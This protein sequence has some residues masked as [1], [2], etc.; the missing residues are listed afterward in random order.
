MKQVTVA[1][2][3]H[4]HQPYYKDPVE[5][6]YLMPWTRLHGIKG[7]YDM[8]SI[9]E[10]YPQIHGTFNLVPS[11]LLQLCDYVNREAHDI[12]QDKS[13]IPANELDDN[14]KRFIL[15][16][17]FMANWETMIRPHERYWQLLIKRGITEIP[18]QEWPDIIH[19]FSE[20][21]LRDLQVWF[22]LCWFGYRARQHHPVIHE[23]I[24]K[25]KDFSEEDKKTVIET[26]YEV[27]SKLIPLYKRLAESGQIEL[28]TSPFYHPI[29]PLVYDTN[30]AGRAMPDAPLPQR[31][32][33]PNDA[34]TQ[35]ER[36][37]SFFE[38]LFGFKPKGMWPSEGSVCPE[39]IPY[40]AEMGIEWIA[41]DEAILTKS[42]DMTNKSDALF[43]PYTAEYDGKSVSI[44]FRDRGLSDLIGFSYA[45]HS[46]DHASND[47]LSHVRAIGNATSLD[48]P[49]VNIILDGE[50]AWEHFPDGGE[51]FFKALYSKLTDDT[52]IHTAT[53]HDFIS[54]HPASCSIKTLH[55]GSW[56][57]HNYRVWIGG[58]E[59]NRA[60]EYLRKT[61][62][63]VEHYLS[64][65]DVPEDIVKIVWEEIFIAEGSDW[66]W[67]YGDMF[68]TDNDEEFDRLFRLHL[69]N[70][71]K[72]LNTAMPSY[73]KEP[74]IHKHINPTVE[75]PVWYID[76]VIDGLHTHFYEWQ[77]AGFFVTESSPGTTM[78]KAESLFK[79]VYFGFSRKM[80]FLR[81]D[82][83]EETKL[84]AN[85]KDIDIRIYIKTQKKLYCLEFSLNFNATRTYQLFEIDDKTN[86]RKMKGIYEEIQAVNIIELAVAFE[87]LEVRS[88]ENITFYVEIRE[89]LIEIER[90]P[91]SDSVSLVIPGDE[92]DSAMWSV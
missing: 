51:A 17:F 7:Y 16:N 68:S 54:K 36:G 76:P 67:W 29:L 22:N 21:D 88:N 10:D 86:D 78:H 47:L 13:L 90:Y 44:V 27:I 35:I 52:Q 30:F 18:E 4:M 46:A 69:S 26:Q 84:I 34:R 23:L 1:F 83:S 82:P 3:W 61:R 53:V 40:F 12:F 33:Y 19:R 62:Q 70:I 81:L 79:I 2:F 49:M 37:I 5:N 89:D 32:H 9:L 41:T 39:I 43:K 50:N 64:R 75:N 31:F 72:V 73:L 74:I 14:D 63:F 58:T 91:R 24:K 25:G 66:F 85:E 71:Y 57:N 56:I 38:Q 65:H 55:S 60:W 59:E 15:W 80:L 28:T 42:I 77:E 45:K 6:V 48:G 11:L 8:P 20:R 87:I 92:F